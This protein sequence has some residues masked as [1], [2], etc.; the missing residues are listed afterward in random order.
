MKPAFKRR[1]LATADGSHTLELVGLDEHYHST[2]GAVQESRHVFI[3]NG[4]LSLSGNLPMISILE[5]GFGTGLNA[6]LTFIESQKS[7]RQV[8]YHALEPFPLEPEEYKVLNYPALLDQTGLQEIFL[9]F[10]ES[11]W[12]RDLELA[13]GFIFRKERKTLQ[14][15][16][17]K[18]GF[19]DLVY[20][21]AFG[22]D[23]QPELWQQPLFGKV[24]QAM[25]PEALLTT[26]CAKGSV[27][28]AMRACGLS[29]EKLPGPPGK[30]EMTRAV[31]INC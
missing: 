17:L 9:K 20:Y 12:D 21:D 7:R 24:S 18:P 2:F 4:L 3:N 28:R 10:H 13:P 15:M 8:F 5:I 26:Y 23:T 22:P 19:F 11:E 27:R 14:E 6:L 25:K 29:V 16:V 30:R 1:I 31:K